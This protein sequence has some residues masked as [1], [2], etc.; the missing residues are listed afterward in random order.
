MAF[1]SS[2]FIGPLAPNQQRLPGLDFSTPSAANSASMTPSLSSYGTLGASTSSNQGVGGAYPIAAGYQAPAQTQQSS[3]G[4]GGGG[5]LSLSGMNP[6]QQNDWALQNGYQGWS[7]YL[8]KQQQ[9]ARNNS[10]AELSAANTAFDYNA[11]QLNNQLGA[12]GNQRTQALSEID[13]GLSGLQNQIKTSR[14]NAQTNTEGQIK[15]AGSIAKST[16]AQ[17]RNVLRALGIIN[18]TAGG[19]LLSKPMNEFDK[20][21]ASL[22]Q[23]LEQRFQ[24]LDDT[25]NQKTAEANAQKNGIIS[26]FTDL[27]GKIQTDLRFNDR[28]RLDA[29][30]QANAAL[31]QRLADIQGSVMQFQQQVAL[32]KQNFAQSLAQIAA[33][34]NPT[35]ATNYMQGLSLTTPTNQSNTAQI[36]QDPTKK[37]QPG[38]SGF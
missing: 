1:V 28:Q 37:Q 5:G 6:A 20:Q 24:E 4:G 29:V 30:K 38:L 27:V 13:L 18:S 31:Q 34:Q 17:N 25:F 9:A 22:Q 26:Q 10:G 33:Q 7:D 3:G 12:L 14:Q 16:Q 15:Q 35:L 21:R 19:E 11:E 8:D 36:Y 23:Q 32:Q 2:N